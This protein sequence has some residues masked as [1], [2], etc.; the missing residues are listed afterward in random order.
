MTTPRSSRERS[1]TGVS[2]TTPR[3]P[4]GRMVLSHTNDGVCQSLA[5]KMK[6]QLELEIT[7]AASPEPVSR[8]GASLPPPAPGTVPLA[9]HPPRFPP[10]RIP[11]DIPMPKGWS[12]DID[13]VGPL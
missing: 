10:F 12:V 6:Q 3:V 11:R 13:P 7:G 1:P 5:E 2:S 4:A 9:D 8:A